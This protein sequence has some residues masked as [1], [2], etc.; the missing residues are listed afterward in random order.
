M[1]LA[2]KV[3]DTEVLDFIALSTG[4]MVSSQRWIIAWPVL[5]S[6]TQSSLTLPLEPFLLDSSFGSKEP[7][8]NVALTFTFWFLLSL[9]SCCKVISVAD[10][11]G[12]LDDGAVPAEA[13]S[14]QGS[15]LMSL[16]L[17][18]MSEGYWLMK[19]WPSS[20]LALNIFEGD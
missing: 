12:R 2:I 5:S 17:A 1:C 11:S 18:F 19:I 20:S 10:V 14:L 7:M 16:E 8:V 13:G 3:F 9:L 15:N 6:S 4:V